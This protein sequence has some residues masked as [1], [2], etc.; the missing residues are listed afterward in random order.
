M[1]L[2]ALPAFANQTLTLLLDFIPGAHDYAAWWL[3]LLEENPTHLYSSLSSL[4]PLRVV[5]VLL[6]LLLL[7]L[8]F[9]PRSLRP[10][11]PRILRRFSCPCLCMRRHKL[12]TIEFATRPS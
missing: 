9:P 8:L 12:A 7:L 10:P 11:T 5:V 6:L 1:S 4:L 2:P 3:K